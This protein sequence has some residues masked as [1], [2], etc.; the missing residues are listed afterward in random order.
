MENNNKSKEIPVYKL[1]YWKWDKN[2]KAHYKYTPLPAE[3]VYEEESLDVLK[4]GFEGGHQITTK[5][6]FERLRK[7]APRVETGVHKTYV[8]CL[9]CGYKAR[10]LTNHLRHFHKVLAVDYKDTFGLCH[11][12]PLECEEVTE[13]RREAVKNNTHVLD[14]LLHD[15]VATRFQ[16]GSAG[17]DS[18]TPQRLE[19]LKRN[20]KK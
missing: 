5:E 3:R 16:K 11:N 13:L 10:S 20:K 8:E 17:N 18:R 9:L 19:I 6:L 1:K 2:G 15:G 12:Q 7:I 4:K 14:N